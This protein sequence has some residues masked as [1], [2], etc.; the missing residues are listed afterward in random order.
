ML[1]RNVTVCEQISQVFCSV[2]RDNKAVNR[3]LPTISVFYFVDVFLSRRVEKVFAEGL[4]D[5]A[6]WWVLWVVLHVEVQASS[7]LF[8]LSLFFS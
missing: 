6:G 3:N 2:I 8:Q 1:F 5:L 4:L 7:G